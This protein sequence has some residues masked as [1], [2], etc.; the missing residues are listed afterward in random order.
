MTFL[1]MGWKILLFHMK[2]LCLESV[3][4][5]TESVSQSIWV[6]IPSQAVRNNLLAL[7]SMRKLDKDKRG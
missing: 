2:L 6:G 3:L 4:V 7:G 1:V 5:S